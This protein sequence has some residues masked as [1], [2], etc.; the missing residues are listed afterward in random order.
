MTQTFCFE[1]H[2]WFIFDFRPAR[3]YYLPEQD[4]PLYLERL[5]DIFC[6]TKQRVVVIG[7]GWNLPNLTHVEPFQSETIPEGFQQYFYKNRDPLLVLPHIMSAIHCFPLKTANIEGAFCIFIVRNPNDDFLR[8]SLV[9]L[10]QTF[11]FP[12]ITLI[13]LSPSLDSYKSFMN[14]LKNQKPFLNDRFPC[15]NLSNARSLNLTTVALENDERF[16]WTDWKQIAALFYKM[17][18]ERTE[19]LL[20]FYI[21]SRNKLNL[22]YEKSRSNGENAI[23]HLLELAKLDTNVSKFRFDLANEKPIPAKLLLFFTSL[24]AA[25][26]SYL[27]NRKWSKGFYRAEKAAKSLESSFLQISSICGKVSYEM[28]LSH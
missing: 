23:T 9:L 6:E 13:C 5:L 14:F 20:N 21:F 27:N 17:V 11:H 22:L 7:D 2:F 15:E 25:R 24:D 28:C 4:L 18:P 8:E 10:S 16:S 26:K 1:C 19:H 12:F 3:V